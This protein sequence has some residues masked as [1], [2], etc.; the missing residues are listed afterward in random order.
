MERT[1]ARTHAYTHAHT[2]K[3]TQTIGV[4][5]R[6]SQLYSQRR[7]FT[8]DCSSEVRRSPGW[9]MFPRLQSWPSLH[10]SE[11]R[12]EES[13]IRVLHRPNFGM[14]HVRK[15]DIPRREVAEASALNRMKAPWFPIWS[16]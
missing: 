13:A 10:S 7:A 9:G 5:C 16:Q 12:A 8:P 6:R 4:R 15:G 3:H 1:H 11:H 2:H 14:R